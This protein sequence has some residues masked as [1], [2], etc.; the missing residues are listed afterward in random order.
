MLIYSQQEWKCWN[1][2]RTR[3][4]IFGICRKKVNFLFILYSTEIQKAQPYF[5]LGR[6][7]FNLIFAVT[8]FIG[9]NI[10]YKHSLHLVNGLESYFNEWNVRNQHLKKVYWV[11]LRI[12]VT[13]KLALRQVKQWRHYVWCWRYNMRSI[14]SDKY[15][16]L[17]TFDKNPSPKIARKASFCYSESVTSKKCDIFSL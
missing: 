17:K 5:F 12:G 7:S 16:S 15:P 8:M 9:Y 11:C 10:G 6:F 14:I 13:C 2:H 4:N 1:F 3:W